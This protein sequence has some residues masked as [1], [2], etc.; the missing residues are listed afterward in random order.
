ELPAPDPAAYVADHLAAAPARY[1][2]HATV[3]TDAPTVRARTYSL[4]GRVHPLTETTSTLDLAGNDPRRIAEQLLGIDLGPTNAI[5]GT[6]ELA[7]HLEQFGRR[8]LRAARALARP[9]PHSG[10][11]GATDRAAHDDCAG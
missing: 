2:L 9:G 8:L 6:P 1:T 4:S 11:T 10:G 3:P 7:P 5:T